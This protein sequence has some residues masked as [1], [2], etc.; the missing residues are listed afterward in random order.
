MNR[1]LLHADDFG[2]NEAVTRGIIEGLSSGLLTGTSLLT[3][4]P[5]APLAVDQWKR[6]EQLRAGG[7]LPA[8][9]MRSNLGDGSLPFDLGV[10]LNLTQ[11]RP[12]TAPRYPEELLDADGRFLSPG[13]LFRKLL[14]GG[15]R[16][17]PALGNELAAQIEWLLDRGLRP[18]HL[19]GH[20]Y[21]EM[22]PVVGELIPGLARRYGIGWVRAACEPGHLRHSLSPGLRLANCGLSSIKHHYAVRFRRALHAAGIR[23]PDA[24]FGASHAG[25]IDLPLMQRFL[26]LA[27]S[28]AVSEIAFHPGR[29]PS[30]SEES[31]ML[32][33]EGWHDPLAAARPRELGLLGSPELSEL[34]LA[35]HFRLTRFDQPGWSSFCNWAA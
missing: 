35:N 6:L 17:R 30:L 16:W 29:L 13:R 26:R 15:R 9:A 23:H 32:E 21:A 3:N 5:A 25:R 24:Y 4:A 31:A 8:A 11:G 19:N 12:L 14:V 18:T 7:G 22:M 27:R 34:L 10:H 28:H 20:Q 33:S 2:L 1:L